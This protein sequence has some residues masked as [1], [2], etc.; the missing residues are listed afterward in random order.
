[1]RFFYPVMILF[2]ELQGRFPYAA[3]KGSERAFRVG[4]HED[5]MRRSDPKKWSLERKYCLL[6]PGK[7]RS[8]AAMSRD[9]L[10]RIVTVGPSSAE[11]PN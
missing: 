6:N 4:N 9:L 2:K 11:L 7:Y 10:K 5:A 3:R 8:V 1:M